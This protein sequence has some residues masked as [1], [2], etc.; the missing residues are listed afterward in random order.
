MEKNNVRAEMARFG[1]TIRDM[2]EFMEMSPNTFSRKLHGKQDWLLNE[3]LRIVNILNSYGANV[4]LGG[5]FDESQYG[6]YA[7]KQ[8][9]V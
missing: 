8:D 2:A 5:L 1:L 7:L 3:A 6:K 4:T 9:V